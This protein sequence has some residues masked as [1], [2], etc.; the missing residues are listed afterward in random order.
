MD[1]L[2]LWR[3]RYHCNIASQT[4]ATYGSD[5]QCFTG[6]KNRDF[7]RFV[8][9]YIT[10]SLHHCIVAFGLLHC[11]SLHHSIT[12]RAAYGSELRCVPAPQNR[13]FPRFAVHYITTSLHHC[14]GGSGHSTHTQQF[15]CVPGGQPGTRAGSLPPH[16]QVSHSPMLPQAPLC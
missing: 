9:H 6:P 4:C 7:P 1:A 15:Y 3:C 8:L 16:T 12:A 11:Y 2:P 14:T 5:L 13:D 10:T